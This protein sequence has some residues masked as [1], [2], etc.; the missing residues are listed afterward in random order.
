MLLSVCLAEVVS[1]SLG[2]GCCGTFMAVKI[3]RLFGKGHPPSERIS[4][5]SADATQ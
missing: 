3:A 5:R 2:D 4:K 1:W